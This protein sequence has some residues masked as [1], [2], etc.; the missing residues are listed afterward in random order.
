[1]FTPF[2][3]LL[4]LTVCININFAIVIPIMPVLMKDFGMSPGRLS[5]AFSSLI[6]ARFLTQAV[7]G[8]LVKKVGEGLVLLINLILY[9]LVMIYYPFVGSKEVFII[10]R[11]F[12]GIFEGFAL[13]SLHSLSIAL[14]N[15]AD[16]G[17]KLGYYGSAFGLGF[18]IGPAIGGTMYDWG[19]MKALFW[20]GAGMGLVG[21][22]GLFIL[23]DAFKVPKLQASVG[24]G[25]SAW[26]IAFQNLRLF[27]Y[28]SSYVLKRVLFVSFMMILPLHLNGVFGLSASRS[29]LYF[30][31]S[32]V[33]TTTLLPY[34]GRVVDK[35]RPISIAFYSMSGMGF[36][37]ALFGV[38]DYE[39]ILLS[40][41]ILETIGFCFLLPAGM[42]IFGNMVGKNPD[43][44][45]V[46]GVFG[47][48]T[49]A[50]A[51]VLPFFLL[52]LYGVSPILA[53]VSVG[54]VCLISAIPFASM[55][56]SANVASVVTTGQ[57]DS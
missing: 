19:G 11:F 51:A 42:K 46:L 6:I 37:I 53:W 54:G 48:L 34:T 15:P 18:I 14:T 52:P 26:T 35:G 57:Q 16:R 41:W 56:Q 27:P 55:M 33:L 45:I 2:N 40:A 31:I 28:Y 44:P 17:K 8:S 38:I 29:A 10:L 3:F 47:S 32:A 39:P 5:L 12:E 7:G 23:Q 22:V 36:I 1:M 4:F 13:L 9:V 50:L 49:D 21:L 20:S 24:S 30:T 43:R 25:P